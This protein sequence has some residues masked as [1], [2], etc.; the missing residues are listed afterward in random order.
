MTFLLSFTSKDT[1]TQ[2]WWNSITRNYLKFGK[3]EKAAAGCDFTI[4]SS[5]GRRRSTN[6]QDKQVGPL[7]E[8]LKELNKEVP[9]FLIRA[10]IVALK[11][12]VFLPNTFL[13]GKCWLYTQHYHVVYRNW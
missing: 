5:N 3:K 8:I 13:K 7:S 10:R 1:L 4:E 12:M 11:L 9:D 2:D 6:F